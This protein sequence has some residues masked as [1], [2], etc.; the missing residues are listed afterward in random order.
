VTV[1]CSESVNLSLPIR[2]LTA[3]SATPTVTDLWQAKWPWDRFLPP[4]PQYLALSPHQRHFTNLPH[5]DFHSYSTDTTLTTAI[6]SVVKQNTIHHQNNHSQFVPFTNFYSSKWR[7]I[8][9]TFLVAGG[10]D[11]LSVVTS[12]PQQPTTALGEG[13]KGDLPA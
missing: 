13:G 4:S 12:K 10:L 1:I 7:K 9:L 6:K 2:S 8:H 11:L 5:S 3:K